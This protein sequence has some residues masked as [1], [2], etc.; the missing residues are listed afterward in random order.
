MVARHG[1]KSK[2][3]TRA[4]FKKALSAI[5]LDLGLAIDYFIFSK[6]LMRAKG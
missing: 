4:D 3:R 6:T 1:M 2:I 5:V